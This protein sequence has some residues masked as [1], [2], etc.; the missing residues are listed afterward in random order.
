M[1]WLI[2]ALTPAPEKILVVA[3]S[4]RMLVQLLSAAGHH[5][6][7]IDCFGDDDTRQW[8]FDYSQAA[9]LALADIEQPVLQMKRRQRIDHVIYGSGF[10]KHLDSVAFLQQHFNV[11]G[12][13][14]AVFAAVQ[15]KPSFFQR[16]D[17]LG[18]NHPAASYTPPGDEQSWLEKPLRGEG[19]LGIR[20]YRPQLGPPDAA[21]FWQC[22]IDGEPMSVLFIAVRERVNIIGYQRQLLTEQE[23][24]AFLFAGV[25]SEPDL[26]GPVKAMLTDWVSRLSRELG[27]RGLNSLDFI[28]QGR[29]CYV[30]EVNARPPASLQL[31]GVYAIAAHMQAVSSGSFVSALD[32]NAYRAYKIVYA[33]KET[34]IAGSV[35]WP[36]W[37][38]DRPR[39]GSIIGQGGPVCSIIAR[40]KTHQQLMNRLQRKQQTLEKILSKV[41]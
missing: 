15:D 40:G 7:A 12:N 18:I 1:S 8:A 13:S 16:L 29:D 6:A 4:A 20:R 2:D 23:D 3:K 19:G 32:A 22:Y 27:L 21:V 37:V 34:R 17:R 30:L 35:D 39:Q 31:Y 33:A 11:L 5:V 24:S 26:P 28:L 14:P 9:G 38:V 41:L 25:V 10:E 36:P